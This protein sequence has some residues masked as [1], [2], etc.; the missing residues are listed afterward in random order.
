MAFLVIQIAHDTTQGKAL[1]FIN[2]GSSS[3]C[4]RPLISDGPSHLPDP[5]V[6]HYLCR[7]QITSVHAK[8]S[9]ER[10]PKL[11]P[12]YL[13]PTIETIKQPSF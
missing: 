4:Y 11:R 13:R 12:Y 2:L 10:L 5:L 9:F 3:N 6:D 8:P 1:S 7:A